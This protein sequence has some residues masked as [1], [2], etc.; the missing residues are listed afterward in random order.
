MPKSKP[1]GET[2]VRVSRIAKSKLKPKKKRLVP[3][4][5]TI[6]SDGN[7]SSPS[8]KASTENLP[9]SFAQRVSKDLAFDAR[10]FAA[11]LEVAP[12]TL[13]RWRQKERQLSLQQSDRVRILEGI[14]KLG[15]DVLGSREGVRSWLQSPVF[16][17]DGSRPID[18]VKTETGRRRVENALHQIEFGMY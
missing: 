12:K 8:R 5:L 15:E 10:D 14:F 3:R 13:T 17:L 18:L 6:V 4:Y 16:A 2:K 7:V 1:N 9:F 11:V